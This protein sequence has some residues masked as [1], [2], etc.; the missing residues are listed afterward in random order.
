MAK[1][2]NLSDFLLDLANTIRTKTGESGPINPQDFSQKIQDIQTGS[3][4]T[5]LE[6]TTNLMMERGDQ[7]IAPEDSATQTM[8][9][10]IVKKPET[11]IS[12]NIR[13]GVEI[14][15]V[16]GDF[17][18]EGLTEKGKTEPLNMSEGNQII[19]PDA[20]TTMSQVTIIKPETLIPSNIKQGV[21]IGGVVGELS[22]TGKEEVAGSATITTNGSQTFSPPSGKVFSDFT[23]TTNVSAGIDTSDATATSRDILQDKT[24]YAKGVKI[25]G[26]IKTYDGSYNVVIPAGTVFTLKNVLTQPN[27][28]FLIIPVGINTGTNAVYFSAILPNGNLAYIDSIDVAYTLSGMLSFNG[29]TVSLSNDVYT[30]INYTD[31]NGQTY[32]PNTWIHPEAKIFS[33]PS[34]MSLSI[35]SKGF[36]WL[37]QNCETI[38]WGSMV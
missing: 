33:V 27:Q 10:V 15:G 11:L 14:G 32:A 38:E 3:A 25:T 16:V 30:W 9:K 7:T 2:N 13:S 6:I 28:G 5:E 18:G 8:S 17:T 29:Y 1:D 19:N 31:S 24:A 35:S 36:E 20:G 21:S 4:K 22:T 37:K 26:A 34:H 12:S 23:V